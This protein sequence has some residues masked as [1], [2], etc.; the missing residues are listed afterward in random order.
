MSVHDS[1]LGQTTV[2]PTQYDA[3]LLFPIARAEGRAALGAT[4]PAFISTGVDVWHVFELSWLD[5]AG[6]P[7]V[8]IGR[9]TV[10]AHSPNLIESKSLKL[11]FNGLNFAA[12]ANNDALIQLVVNDLSKAAGAA[13]QFELLNVDELETHQPQGICIDHLEMTTSEVPREPDA[14]LLKLNPTSANHDI[15]ETLYSNLLRS[16]CP[17]TGQPDWGTIFIRY[18]S[19]KSQGA[20]ICRNSLLTYIVSYRQHSGFHEQCVE[21]IFSDIWQ[22]FKPEKL[23]IHAQYTRRGGLDINPCRSSDP[24]WLPKVLRLARQ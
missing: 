7:V 4:A 22:I 2:Y 9:I 12:F 15:E 14:R 3:T 24:L 8:A 1:A 17:V 23:A 10:P 21:Q 16:N 11:Y 18:Q 20:E 13:V 5:E 19:A 6:K